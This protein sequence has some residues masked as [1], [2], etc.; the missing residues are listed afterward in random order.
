M[1][2][3]FMYQATPFLFPTAKTNRN[4]SGSTAFADFS[5]KRKA[6]E[7]KHIHNYY[8]CTGSSVENKRAEHSD[9]KACN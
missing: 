1:T 7:E 4:M 9:K 3:K 5:D 6:Q 8:A 2:Q